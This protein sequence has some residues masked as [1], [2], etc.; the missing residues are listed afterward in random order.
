M[1]GRHG[2]KKL[3]TQSREAQN[4][5]TRQRAGYAAG[6]GSAGEAW[7]TEQRIAAAGKRAGKFYYFRKFYYFSQLSQ[8]SKV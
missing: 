8:V 7:L 2:Q 5:D 1:G 4:T 6:I 3:L